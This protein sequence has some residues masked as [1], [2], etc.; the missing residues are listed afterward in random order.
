MLTIS[1]ISIY[2]IF[3]LFQLAIALIFLFPIIALLFSIIVIF[4]LRYYSQKKQNFGLLYIKSY[5]IVTVSS[6]FELL[7]TYLYHVIFLNE[8]LLEY[9]DEDEI[10]IYTGVDYIFI[11]LVILFTTLLTYLWIKNKEKQ[12]IS[13]KTSF[14]IVIIYTSITYISIFFIDTFDNKTENDTENNITIGLIK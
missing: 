14:I 7:I 9:V 11:L 3:F 5:F 4:V 6:L 12:K 1:G 10:Y 8:E 13:L 2:S